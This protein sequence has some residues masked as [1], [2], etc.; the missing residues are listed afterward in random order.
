MWVSVVL[1][2]LAKFDLG[3]VFDVKTRPFLTGRSAWA[4]ASSWNLLRTPEVV[5]V[6]TWTVRSANRLLIMFLLIW[7]F[8]YSL[9]V[10]SWWSL[11][12]IIEMLKD[13]N[14]IFTFL[15]IGSDLWMSVGMGL[16]PGGWIMLV[17][18]VF[19]LSS[20]QLLVD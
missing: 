2:F 19:T 4:N 5:V 20:V 7:Y 8:A 1:V 17:W 13:K 16:F 10:L 6:G 18:F 11:H 3:F 15:I 9:W 12:D 14:H